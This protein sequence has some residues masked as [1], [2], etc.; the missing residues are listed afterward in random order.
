M[1]QHDTSSI[2]RRLQPNEEA[3]SKKAGEHP[4]RMVMNRRQGRQEMKSKYQDLVQLTDY[5]FTLPSNMPVL[6]RNQTTPP[7]LN[8]SISE[9][10][11]TESG[12]LPLFQKWSPTERK[13]I[14]QTRALKI[15]QD[16][17]LS[18]EKYT[19]L[20]EKAYLR[21]PVM[22]DPK[23]SVASS[24]SVQ[25]VPMDFY[26]Q[27]HD[28]NNLTSSKE[29]NSNIEQKNNNDKAAMATSKRI[30][31]RNPLRL[32]QNNKA[33]VSEDALLKAKALQKANNEYD[34]YFGVIGSEVGIRNKG[35]IA[36]L[37]SSTGVEVVA[38]SAHGFFSHAPNGQLHDIPNLC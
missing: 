36:L 9:L 13:K 33:R 26:M 12:G 25:Q 27:G 35:T 10:K 30:L 4:P 15:I 34:D 2:F 22:L 8:D 18:H 38:P 29:P 7:D 20:N 1:Y 28:N 21:S 3:T 37:P 24:L 16:F 17:E 6:E 11:Q 14:S 5:S 32:L 31:S 23:L 19:E